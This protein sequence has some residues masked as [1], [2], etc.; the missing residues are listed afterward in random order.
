MEDQELSPAAS[1][2]FHLAP[3]RKPLLASGEPLSSK[4]KE[5]SSSQCPGLYTS[6]P[7]EQFK[8]NRIT[9]QKTPLSEKAGERDPRELRAPGWLTP[10]RKRPS[11]FREWGG[12]QRKSIR[13]NLLLGRSGVAPMGRSGGAPRDFC[14][15]LVTVRLGHRRGSRREGEGCST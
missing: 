1:S 9:A 10:K 7:P 4:S 3:T 5:W 13:F 8:T 12:A 15:V 6:T 11:G 14:G 2:P